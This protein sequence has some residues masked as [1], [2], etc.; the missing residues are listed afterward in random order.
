MQVVGTIIDVQLVD[1]A[2]DIEVS[3][4]DA[5]GIA[6]R[7]LAGAWPIIEV[8]G[9]VLVAQHH[10]GEV[11]LTVGHL[12]FQDSSTQR[13]EFHTRPTGVDEFIGGDFTT[14]SLICINSDA[15]HVNPPPCERRR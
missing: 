11:A 10:V 15:L 13:R 3:L 8:V 5:V 1:L 2:V 6:S 9:H 4:A 7:H 14:L 12:D